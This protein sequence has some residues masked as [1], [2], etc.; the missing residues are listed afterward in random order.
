MDRL[1]TTQ[2]QTNLQLF[3]EISQITDIELCIEILSEY[4]WNVE[5]AV[6]SFVH[7]TAPTSRSQPTQQTIAPTSSSQPATLAD[8]TN[9]RNREVVASNSIFDRILHPIKWLFQSRPI[10]LDPE[11][12]TRNFISE[13]NNEFGVVHPRLE[14][15]TY[16][17]AVAKAHRD[18]KFLLVYLHS[19][20]H[21]DTHG[22][23]TTVFCSQVFQQFTDENFVVWA[24]RVW[25]PEAFNLSM[26]FR[27]SSF[28]FL[29]LLLCHSGNSVQIAAK[30][31]GQWDVTEVTLRLQVL[32]CYIIFFYSIVTLS[33]LCFV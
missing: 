24:G 17:Q 2:Q 15:C 14:Q 12:D 26:Q 31:E 11:A 9:N 4:S 13:F 21:E 20:L 32:F 16:N 7:G 23:C 27:V 22:F 8:S 28:P 3:Q 33:I 1:L 18:S 29:A 19:P 30:I 6:E 5:S 25:D 10:S